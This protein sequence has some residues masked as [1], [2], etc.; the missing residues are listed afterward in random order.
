MP[1]PLE[2]FLI[3]KIPTIVPVSD[4]R[5]GSAFGS[6]GGGNLRANIPTVPRDEKSVPMA[7]GLKELKVGIEAVYKLKSPR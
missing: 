3:V 7:A 4:L 5:Q 2:V 1:M 6:R